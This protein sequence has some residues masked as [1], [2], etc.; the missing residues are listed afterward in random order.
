MLHVNTPSPDIFWRKQW[1]KQQDYLELCHKSLTLLKWARLKSKLDYIIKLNCGGV[2]TYASC[3][4]ASNIGELWYIYIY[5]KDIDIWYIV[6]I[7]RFWAKVFWFHIES[8]SEWD[9]NPWPHAYCA[10]ALI[11]ELSGWMIRC[12]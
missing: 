11:T 2:H 12:A 4:T 9:S 5:I 1:V 7:L 3:K 6:F 8:W 10:H